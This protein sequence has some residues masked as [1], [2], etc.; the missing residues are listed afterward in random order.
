MTQQIIAAA[1]PLGI[2][3]LDRNIVG[4]ERACESEGLT[5]I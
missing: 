3:A 5:L 1:S 4:K 2:S